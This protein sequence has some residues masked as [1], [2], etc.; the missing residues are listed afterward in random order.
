MAS[1]ADLEKVRHEKTYA[2]CGKDRI[3]NVNVPDSAGHYASLGIDNSFS[4]EEFE[5]TMRFKITEL[6]EDKVCFDMINV[7]PPIANSL[8]RVLLAEVPTVAIEK[9]DLYQNTGVIHDEVFCHRLGL[10]PL[11]IEPDTM[12][13]PD[14]T[15]D[16]CSDPSSCIKLKLH[17]KCTS[18]TRSVYSKE[19]EWIPLDEAQK[20]K[21]KK[22]PPKAVHDD[23]LI[24]KLRPGQEIE[25]EMFAV[26]GVGKDHAKFSPVATAFYRMLPV[27][28]FNPEKP[29]NKEEAKE[30]KQLCA[31]DVFDIEDSGEIV[32]RKPRD[33]TTCRACVDKFGE[34]R[35]ILEKNKTH[36]LFEV[37]S[38]GQM[39]AV[40]VEEKFP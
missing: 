39:P 24:T 31:P 36:Y 27:V 6:S 32:V 21:Y 34:D 30:L 26:K 16:F 19:L 10:I 12:E 5:K 13:W 22:N 11:K 38:A 7:D 15:G 3:E 18:G 8:R 4:I 1:Q 40:K 17:V 25:C 37:E 35:V 9:V 20:E 28:R 33:C 29:F 14:P 2:R 23:I